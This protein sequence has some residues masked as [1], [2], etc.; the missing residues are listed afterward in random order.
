[1]WLRDGRAS[2]QTQRVGPNDLLIAATARA[3]D[4]VLITHNSGEFVRV[5]GLRMEDWDAETP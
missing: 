5:T 4:A 3:H 1:M 2:R